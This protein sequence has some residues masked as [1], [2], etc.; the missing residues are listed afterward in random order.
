MGGGQRNPASLRAYRVYMYRP[1]CV[2][3][4]VV[5]AGD[6]CVVPGLG[7]KGLGLVWLI[8]IGVVS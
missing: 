3:V 1:C 5:E 7:L 2:R 6:G 4:V 8:D